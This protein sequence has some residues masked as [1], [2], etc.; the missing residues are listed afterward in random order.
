MGN[1]LQ[2]GFDKPFILG[3]VIEGVYMA[4]NQSNDELVQAETAYPVSESQVQ[5]GR[6][7][8]DGNG[9]RDL[10]PV[11]LVRPDIIVNKDAVTQSK[12]D[13]LDEQQRQHAQEVQDKQNAKLNQNT[14]PGVDSSDNDE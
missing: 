12:V 10:P 3:L 14:K 9:Q 1:I 8:V 4:D 13:N 2:L 5:P 6:E 11:D 7:A